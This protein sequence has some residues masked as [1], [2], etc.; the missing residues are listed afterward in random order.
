MLEL[1]NRFF[2]G[3]VHFHPNGLFVL[4]CL[5]LALN[6]DA[7]SIT[8]LIPLLQEFIGIVPLFLG[9][10]LLKI[11]ECNP[12][13]LLGSLVI[14]GRE[15]LR[16]LG[17]LDSSLCE[18][19]L[20]VGV[21]KLL[22]CRIVMLL[23]VFYH[24]LHFIFTTF[25]LKKFVYK[26]QLKFYALNFLLLWLYCVQTTILLNLLQQILATIK[27]IFADF[28]RLDDSI[29]KLI[30]LILHNLADDPINLLP[31]VILFQEHARLEVVQLRPRGLV[32][33]GDARFYGVAH[34][35]GVEREALLGGQVRVFAKVLT[36]VDFGDV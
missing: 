18:Q 20:I 34:L 8:L 32:E 6:L 29:V 11:V 4:L 14:A 7:Q 28:L 10:K 22:N 16:R 19:P 33:Q 5:R 23:L 1:P 27:H 36:F 25:Y 15:I 31:R 9:P 24:V 13:K 30:I 21:Y 17:V 26:S 2:R 3:S 35:E 12:F